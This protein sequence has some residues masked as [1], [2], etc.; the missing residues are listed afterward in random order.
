LPSAANLRIW[1]VASSLSG[2]FSRKSAGAVRQMKT[3]EGGF[4]DGALEFLG[5][6]L[7]GLAVA[8]VFD[9]NADLLELSGVEV[10]ETIYFCFHRFL[11]VV[12]CRWAVWGKRR[13]DSKR[14]M[15]N[16]EVSND[17]GMPQ[18][19]NT[20]RRRATLRSGSG[21]RI[22]AQLRGSRGSDDGLA[23]EPESGRSKGH[24]VSDC[25]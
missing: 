13:W 3:L 7:S 4:V 12:S 1:R 15:S 5:G 16:V 20:Q 17:Q 14:A 10:F 8:E 21:T 19:P 2:V 25:K 23:P 24:S 18:E 9:E 11:S 22:D 6:A